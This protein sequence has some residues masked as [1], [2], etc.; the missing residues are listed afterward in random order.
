MILVPRYRFLGTRNPMEE[1]TLSLGHSLYQINPIYPPRWRIILK[2]CCNS[3]TN[4]RNMILVSRYKFLG[5]RNPMEEETL[6]F[7]HS[8]YQINPRWQPRCRIILKSA[9]TFQPVHLGQGFL[10]PYGVAKP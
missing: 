5:T 3:S 6:S 9:I 2:K 7:D 8:L 1:E 4:S 10:T